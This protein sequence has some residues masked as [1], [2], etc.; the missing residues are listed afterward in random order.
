MPNAHLC[1]PATAAYSELV[2]NQIVEVVRQAQ[3][4]RSQVQ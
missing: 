2:Y 3:A 4:D 1:A